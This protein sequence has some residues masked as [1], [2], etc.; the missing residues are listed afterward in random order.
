MFSKSDKKNTNH[1]PKFDGFRLKNIK[2]IMPNHD[3]VHWSLNYCNFRKSCLPRNLVAMITPILMRSDLLYHFCFCFCFF[4]KCLN[5][6][7]GLGLTYYKRFKGSKSR[8]D[9]IDP[10]SYRPTLALWK[11]STE[12]DDLNVFVY[13]C[14]FLG[15]F[16]M[17]TITGVRLGTSKK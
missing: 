8:A 16:R 1:V 3:N 17:R 15:S 10:S 11:K 14:V 4:N 12:L 2:L 7:E 9:R 13:G 6:S 5:T